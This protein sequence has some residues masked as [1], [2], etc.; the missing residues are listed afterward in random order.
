[1]AAFAADICQKRSLGP[2]DESFG[3]VQPDDMAGNALRIAVVAVSFQ[4][5]QGV[6][7]ERFLPDFARFAVAGDAEF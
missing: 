7:V 3:A 5:L 2:R 6:A 1:M 4:C